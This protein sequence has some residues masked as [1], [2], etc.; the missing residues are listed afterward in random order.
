MISYPQLYISQIPTKTSFVP[1]VSWFVSVSCNLTKLVEIE[2]HSGVFDAMLMHERWIHRF[3]ELDYWEM[4][5][6]LFN[7]SRLAL[8]FTNHFFSSRDSMSRWRVFPKKTYNTY[9]FTDTKESEK[10][11]EMMVLISNPFTFCHLLGC[12]LAMQQSSRRAAK[13]LHHHA[14]SSKAGSCM[15]AELTKLNLKKTYMI[16]ASK[17]LQILYRFHSCVLY[18]CV[19]VSMSST[20]WKKISS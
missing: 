14:K 8:L 9:I 4:K 17:C 2:R 10:H 18:A 12:L 15:Q 13:N 16:I 11:E 19:C 5:R 7:S 6:I 20:F 1:F 3:P